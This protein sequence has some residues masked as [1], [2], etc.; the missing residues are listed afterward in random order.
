[1]MDELST[2]ARCRGLCSVLAAEL[3][4]L[5]PGMEM[6]LGD[7]PGHLLKVQTF[8]TLRR[9]EFLACLL[10]HPAPPLALGK[11][12]QDIFRLAHGESWPD[13]CPSLQTHLVAPRPHCLLTSGLSHLCTAPAMQAG[14]RCHE[15]RSQRLRPGCLKR[16]RSKHCALV[17]AA[18]D[19]LPGLQEHLMSKIQTFGCLSKLLRLAPFS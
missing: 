14:Q 13:L 8:L 1:M 18:S 12:Y 3:C 16:T 5:P 15:R 7:L 4:L 19:S 2:Q 10:Q 6:V 9:A 17:A 11:L